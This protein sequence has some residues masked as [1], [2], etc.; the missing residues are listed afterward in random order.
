MCSCR[1]PR[2]VPSLL[3]PGPSTCRHLKRCGR[4]LVRVGQNGQLC[5]LA[6]AGLHTT[7]WFALCLL[8]ENAAHEPL[9]S[10]TGS[11]GW[12]SG[13]PAGEAAPADAQRSADASGTGPSS[14]LVEKASWAHGRPAGPSG[15]APWEQPRAL[16]LREFPSLAAA[17]AATQQP[18]QRSSGHPA[19]E[20]GAWDEDERGAGP[21]GGGPNR[22]R[23]PRRD[24]PYAYGGEDG[25]G[26]G[27]PPPYYGRRGDFSPPPWEREHPHDR[28]RFDGEEPYGRFSRER[29]PPHHERGGWRDE[30]PP[31]DWRHD[32]CASVA[33]PIAG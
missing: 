4:A 19:P 11:S 18:S 2:L 30:P 5:R 33:A 7:K 6:A 20:S 28:R 13:G 24:G 29:E 22:A 10:A 23:S 26:Y 15:P 12:S 1:G 16:S 31:R 21:P 8:Q 32:R 9:P 25:Y 3:C 17:A 27:R 14:S